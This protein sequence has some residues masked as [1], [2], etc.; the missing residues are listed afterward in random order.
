MPQIITKCLVSRTTKLPVLR[1][2]YKFTP[3][4]VPEQ[5]D[6]CVRNVFW[7]VVYFQSFFLQPIRTLLS[8]FRTSNS[9]I[10]CKVTDINIS[11]LIKIETIFLSLRN[12]FSRYN[13]LR[14]DHV[15]QNP[16]PHYILEDK[17]Y[18]K[19]KNIFKTNVIKVRHTEC[20]SK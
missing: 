17:A 6:F 8:K 12:I 5:Q 11:T 4:H 16:I 3:T 15:G 2:R 9:V 20:V 18:R 14:V 1:I 7:H 10:R 19:V 13:K